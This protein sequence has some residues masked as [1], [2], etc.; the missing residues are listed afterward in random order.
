M[1]SGG[2]CGSWDEAK[3]GIRFRIVNV[4]IH[5]IQHFGFFFKNA[6]PFEID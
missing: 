6:D 1:G 2:R 4:I 3:T 5:G